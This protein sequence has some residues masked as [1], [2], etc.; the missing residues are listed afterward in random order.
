MQDAPELLV[1][2]LICRVASQGGFS[3][4]HDLKMLGDILGS[5]M[6]AAMSRQQGNTAAIS[7]SRYAAN[8]WAQSTNMSAAAGLAATAISNSHQESMTADSA[9]RI[10]HAYSPA[11]QRLL[12]F[13]LECLQLLPV[14]LAAALAQEVLLR[15]LAEALGKDHETV[16]KSL[17]A[18]AVAGGVSIA[19]ISG[20]TAAKECRRAAGTAVLRSFKGPGARQRLHVLGYMLGVA[21]W[22]DDC[23]QQQKQQVQT[24]AVLANSTQQVVQQIQQQP[25]DSMHML[26]GVATPAGQQ[27]PESQRSTADQQ[28]EGLPVMQPADLAEFTP[29]ADVLQANVQASTGAAQTGLGSSSSKVGDSLLPVDG[30]CIPA[31]DSATAEAPASA[32]AEGQP[33][34]T[35]AATA[36]HIGSATAAGSAEMTAA[37]TA[38]SD[39]CHQLIERIRRLKGV[40]VVM[41]GE[42]AEAFQ[43]TQRTLGNAVEKVRMANI[44]D[45]WQYHDS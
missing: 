11:G 25:A 18:A 7:T 35:A 9:T 15:P 31:K 27:A 14:P 40:G 4:A 39:P 30:A 10:L 37:S 32:E 23:K 28:S 42:A 13:I 24:A 33:V 45:S 2:L 43:A 3:A 6:T 44:C 26:P 22:Q 16:S 36:A 21:A 5:I 17:L 38:T 19:H 12:L 34:I 8:T 20:H 1:S 29:Q 41:E